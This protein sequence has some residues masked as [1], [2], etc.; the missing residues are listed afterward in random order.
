M[1][2]NN[3]QLYLSIDG[4]EQNINGDIDNGNWFGDNLN[5]DTFTFSA[6]K[7]NGST[8]YD[9]ITDKEVIYFNQELSD[10]NRAAIITYLKDKHGL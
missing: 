8:F 10:A 1:Y 3:S 6:L 7:L 9:N 5:L 4:V 2:A